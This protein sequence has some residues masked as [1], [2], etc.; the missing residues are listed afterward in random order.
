[1]P[2]VTTASPAMRR[3]LAEARTEDRGAD[4]APAMNACAVPKHATA[5][6]ADLNMASLS[7]QAQ[8]STHRQHLRNMLSQGATSAHM[9][10]SRAAAVQPVQ[11][12]AYR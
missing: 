11:K 3:E 2:I 9:A 7:L 1:V 10:G 12:V 8:G 6:A 5:T 4:G